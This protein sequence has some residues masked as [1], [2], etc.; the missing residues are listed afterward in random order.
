MQVLNEKVPG[1]GPDGE[2]VP[3]KRFV[4]Q[5]MTLEMTSEYVRV[6]FR[7]KCDDSPTEVAYATES[8]NKLRVNIG[9][10]GIML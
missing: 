5:F 10:G 6:N 2:L 7:T 8:V 3:D 9:A 1:I 4:E